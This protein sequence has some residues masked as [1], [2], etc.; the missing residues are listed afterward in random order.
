M[1]LN[2]FFLYLLTPVLLAACSFSTGQETQGT[3]AK[4]RSITVVG[5]GEVKA[6]PDIAQVI[7]AVRTREKDISAAREE[8][9][10]IVSTALAVLKNSRIQESDIKMEYLHIYPDTTSGS[11]PTIL[12]YI[13]QTKIRVTLHDVEVIDDV[14]TNVLKTGITDVQVSFQVSDIESYREQA[15]SLALQK[16]KIKASNMANELGQEIG[17]P[18]S[19]QE[20]Q[21]YSN[22]LSGTFLADTRLDLGF[23]DSFTHENMI[24]F[25]QVPIKANVTVE[26]LLK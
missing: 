10:K 13:A 25:G 11:N 1:N 2:K 4:Q 24:A 18:I 14:L 7:F 21:P 8:N 9:E 26:F 16:A 3:Q 20:T 5:D 15:R 19:I 6:S 22:Y 12:G 17:E 23:T